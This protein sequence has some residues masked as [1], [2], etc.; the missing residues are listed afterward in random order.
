MK[1]HKKRSPRWHYM[2]K[3]INSRAGHYG[4]ALPVDRFRELNLSK[5]SKCNWSWFWVGNHSFKEK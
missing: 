2:H 5:I 4:H 1:S 3:I